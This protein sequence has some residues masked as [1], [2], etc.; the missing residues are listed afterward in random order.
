MHHNH[1][2]VDNEEDLVAFRPVVPSN[3]GRLLLVVP[4]FIHHN[5]IRVASNKANTTPVPPYCDEDGREVIDV[6]IGMKSVTPPPQMGV[7]IEEVG[8]KQQM[9]LIDQK[10]VD[11]KWKQTREKLGEAKANFQKS[12]NQLEEELVLVKAEL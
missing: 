4:S 2:R 10:N 7:I 12:Y 6:V 5:Q 1:I 8:E 3:R 11:E 9:K